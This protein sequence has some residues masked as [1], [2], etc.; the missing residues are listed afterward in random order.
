[1]TDITADL[2]NLYK[3]ELEKTMNETCPV[4]GIIQINEVFY[5][6]HGKTPTT[7][8]SVASRVCQYA[9]K[10]GCINNKGQV[11]KSL[12]YVPIKTEINHLKLAQDILG[13][14]Q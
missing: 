9:K 7:P 5:Y 13:E 6:S 2:Y 1:M 8:D 10:P 14:S 11:N 12:E 4:C 3:H